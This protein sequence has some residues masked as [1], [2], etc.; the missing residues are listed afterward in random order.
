MQPSCQNLMTQTNSTGK[1]KWKQKSL[2]PTIYRYQWFPFKSL[3]VRDYL[4]CLACCQESF[5]SLPS[6]LLHFDPHPLN[7]MGIMNNQSV[8]LWWFL[9]FLKKKNFKHLSLITLSALQKH[10]GGG[11][12]KNNYINVS[13]QTHKY[14]SE[15]QHTVTSVAHSFPLPPP[16]HSNTNTYREQIRYICANQIPEEKTAGVGG[17]L[18]ATCLICQLLKERCDCPL[19]I[20][21]SLMPALS[22]ALLIWWLPSAKPCPS[23]DC[24]QPSPA[25]LVTAL[26]QALPVW[27]LPS[28]KP[29]PSG[30]CLQPSPAR[31]VTALNQ[32]KLVTA[33]SQVLPSWWP[34]S[35]K[36][37]PPGDCH[38]PSPVS[39]VHT[40]SCHQ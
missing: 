6:W 40:S 9:L 8:H 17:T 26:S 19:P 35:A 2:L 15:H 28:A 5:W 10:E 1:P 13:L 25:H 31:L 39:L 21:A 4:A 30:D 34:P 38:Q 27:W 12:N 24:P 36:S 37:Y 18:W 20:Y 11:E 16:P 22:Q 7:V 14:T 23:S 3:K 29:C 33:L 32:V